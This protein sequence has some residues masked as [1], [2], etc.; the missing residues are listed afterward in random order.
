VLS[1]PASLHGSLAAAGGA[2]L[3]YSVT[4]AIAA[5]AGI[6]APTAARRR[7]ALEVLKILLLRPPPGR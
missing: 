4:V 1:L 2:G 5:L 7:A 3:L 6:F